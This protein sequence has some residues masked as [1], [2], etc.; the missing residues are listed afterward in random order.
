MNSNDGSVLQ[1]TTAS[2]PWRHLAPSGWGSKLALGPSEPD[3]LLHT[4]LLMAAL[5]LEPG[6]LRDLHELD[7]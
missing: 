4:R 5:A 1:L 6:E 2:D 7:E 3:R